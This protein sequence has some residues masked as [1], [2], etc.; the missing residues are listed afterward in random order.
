[1]NVDVMYAIKHV[2]IR[3]IEEITGPRSTKPCG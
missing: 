3:R 2:K 1:M